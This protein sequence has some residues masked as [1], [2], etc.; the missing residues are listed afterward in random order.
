[1]TTAKASGVT[2]QSLAGTLAF[3]SEQRV[4]LLVARC[5]AADLAAAQAME[6]EGFGLMDTLVYFSRDVA[7]PQPEDGAEVAVRDLA[8]GETSAVVEVA[9]QAFTGYFG[10]YHADPKLERRQCDEV[11]VDWARRTCESADRAEGVLV[12]AAGGRVLAFATMRVNS[13]EEGEGVLFGVA[14]AAQGRGIY[15]SLMIGGMRWC[16]ARRCRRMVVSTQIANLA[17][18]K[19]WTR[20]GFEPSGALLTFHKWF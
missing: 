5:P 20:L 3:C 16:A 17:V 1:M 8:A 6:R 9:R 19:V 10:H 18:Q 11:Y 12:A 15:R 14:P 13:A 7:G 2:A 4:G